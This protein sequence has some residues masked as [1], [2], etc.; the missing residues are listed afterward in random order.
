MAIPLRPAEVLSSQ[1]PVQNWLSTD[2]AKSKLF[3][4]RRSVGQFINKA[5]IWGLRPDFHYCQTIAGLLIWG[6]LSDNRTGLSFTM[7]SIQ[8][9]YIYMLLPEYIYNIYEASEEPSTSRGRG[10]QV[11]HEGVHLLRWAGLNMLNKY[12]RTNKG[13]SYWEH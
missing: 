10:P 9:I 2:Y 12:Q 11:A 7:Y 8:Y 6:T 5:P 13:P 1:T 4:D 3:Y